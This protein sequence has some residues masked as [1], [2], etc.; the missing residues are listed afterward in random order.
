MNE[1]KRNTA[2]KERRLAELLDDQDYDKLLDKLEKWWVY[3]K[4]YKKPTEGQRFESSWAY[5]R[6]H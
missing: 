4:D 5:H 2:E 1:E 3:I 6:H